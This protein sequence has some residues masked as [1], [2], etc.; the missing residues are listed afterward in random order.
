MSRHP[1]F[2]SVSPQTGPTLKY[3]AQKLGVKTLT[4]AEFQKMLG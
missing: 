1:E 4:E 2:E 3:K